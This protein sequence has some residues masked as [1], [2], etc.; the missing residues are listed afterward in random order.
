MDSSD[1]QDLETVFADLPSEFDFFKQVYFEK[2]RPELSFREADRT[3]AETRAKQFT[4]F[5][6]LAAVIV[7]VAAIVFLRNPVFAALGGI[8]GIG[9]HSFGRQE[10]KSINNKAKLLIVDEVTQAFDL[11]YTLSPAQPPVVREFQ[12]LKLL[13]NYDR[14]KFEDGLAGK[15]QGAPFEFFEAHLERKET[16]TDS[17][18]RSRTQ[19]VTVFKGQCLIVHFPKK[20]HGVT[21]VFRDAGIFNVFKGL[22]RH[23]DRVRLEDP[24]FEKAFEVVSTDQVEA[25]FLLTPDF[26]ERLLML[27]EAFHGGKLRCAFSGDELFVCLEGG[28]LFE[29]G[30]MFTPLD[31][32]LRVKELLL[33]FA[34][35][36]NLIDVVLSRN[37]QL[38]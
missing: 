14:S 28:D 31:N 7:A 6:V 21:K 18:G 11:A 23:E 10:L 12:S 29:P 33:D 37:E 8:A 4:G 27:E 22:G 5:G 36:F 32:P 24:K 20:F 34:A 35:L 1:R 17:K 25:R 26:M 38:K 13:P 16:T 19:Y 2:I 9:L 3:K 30:S 15:R